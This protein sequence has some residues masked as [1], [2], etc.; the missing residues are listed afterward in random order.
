L[1]A[2][3]GSLLSLPGRPAEAGQVVEF[4][5]NATARR[6]DLTLLRLAERRGRLLF[7]LLPVLSPGRTALLLA[8][9][10]PQ[11]ASEVVAAGELIER[12]C[13]ELRARGVILA[14]SLLDPPDSAAQSLMRSHHFAAMS[15]LIYV[16]GEPRRKQAVP[17]LPPGLQWVPYSAGTHE[18]FKQ[19]IAATYEQSLDCPSLNGL[20]EMEDVVAGHKASGDFDASLW[21]LLCRT[22]TDSRNTPDPLGVLLLS[23]IAQ[24]DALELVYLGLTRAARGKKLGDLMVKQALAAVAER[25]LSRLTL[26]VDAQNAPALRL[27]YRNGLVRVG[28]KVAMMRDLRA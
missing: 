1:T 25:K 27:Y 15:E 12:L 10:A 18:L 21:G 11:A 16:S 8:S 22:P 2:V 9:P 28:R 14:Q 7:C 6:I 26:A 4:L 17:P 5:R 13:V 3:V 20:R 19:T 23:P 24:A